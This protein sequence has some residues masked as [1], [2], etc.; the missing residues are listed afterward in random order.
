M[1]ISINAEKNFDK[2][3]HPFMIKTLNKEGIKGTYLNII[4]AIWQTHKKHYTQQG[5]TRSVSLQIRNKTGMSTFT[6]FTQHSTRNSR[7][8]NQT[9]RIKDTQIKK[10]AVK[11]SLFADNVIPPISFF[12]RI[13][14]AHRGLLWFHINF[15][16]IC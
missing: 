15:W 4:R 9:R 13:T 6:S 7:Y 12:F 8:S 11:L 5:K 2:I 14:V 1:F 10:E 3:Q 16:N